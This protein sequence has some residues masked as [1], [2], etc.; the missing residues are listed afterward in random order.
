MTLNADA[1]KELKAKAKLEDYETESMERV[2]GWEKELAEGEKWAKFFQYDIDRCI[3]DAEYYEK[4]ATN[5]DKRIKSQAEEIEAYKPHPGDKNRWVEAVIA[6]KSY[7]ESIPDKADKVALLYR[8]T[9]LDPESKK[10]ENLLQFMLG[11]AALDKTPPPPA[12]KPK[13]G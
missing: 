7:L 2:K 12:R 11:K 1:I 10:A 3:A 6:T 13:K 9:V 5:I 8:L 4:V